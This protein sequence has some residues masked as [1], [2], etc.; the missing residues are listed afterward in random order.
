ML[1][2][3]ELSK[4]KLEE[5]C[6]VFQSSAKEI[7]EQS[8]KKLKLMEEQHNLSIERLKSTLQDISSKVNLKEEHARNVA[9]VEEL[10]AQLKT[11]STD[12]HDKLEGLKKMVSS[13]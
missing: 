13:I 8:N 7:E 10:S 1:T 2:K 6:R 3:T 11:L 9:N 4:S 5:L 12:Y